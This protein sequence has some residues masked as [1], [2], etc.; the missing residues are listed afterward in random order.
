[1][2]VRFV[3]FLIL[4]MGLIPALSGQSYDKMWKKVQAMQK[5]DRPR[6][7]LDLTA[8]IYR[9]ANR[10]RNVP[11]ML[12]AYVSGMEFREKITPDS[13]SRDI[14]G[15][16][17]W[18]AATKEPLDAAVLHS[19][20]AEMY[21]DYF[22][23]RPLPSYRAAELSENNTELSEW[24]GT[25]FV[26]KIFGH[27]RASLHDQELL[28]K[29]SVDA[30]RPVVEKGATSAYFGH[31][32][33][34]LLGQRAVA[35]LEPLKWRVSDFYP[36]TQS[37][38]EDAFPATPEFLNRTILQ[39]SDYDCLGE[40]LRIDQSM[41]RHYTATGDLRAAVLV[42]LNRVNLS[43][44]NTGRDVARPAGNFETFS[45]SPY[46]QALTR[47]SERY[48]P[49]DVCA[50]VYKKMADVALAN[51]FPSQAMRIV[52]D[53]LQ[54]YPDYDRINLFRQLESDILEPRLSGRSVETVYP[55]Q[56]FGID[57][58]YRN[59]AGFTLKLYRVNVPVTSELLD[60]PNEKSFRSRSVKLEKSFRY[61]LAP[62]PDYLEKDTSV[63]VAAP[64]EGVWLMEIVPDAKVNGTTSWLLY[65]TRL[66]AINRALPGGL[67]EFV[68]VDARSGYPVA[69]A[70]V[71]LYRQDENRM[72]LSGQ[73]KTGPDGTAGAKE[74]RYD[75]YRALKGNDQAMP[76]NRTG[77]IRYGRSYNS[78]SSKE[79]SLFTDRGIYRP[80]QTVYV[81]GIAYRTDGDSVRVLA[82]SEYTLSLYDVNQ[83][84]LAQKKVKTNEF[85][86]FAG[87]FQLPA[88]CLPGSFNIRAGGI[89]AWFR[90]EE[91]KR[92]TFDVTFNTIRTAY[93]IG[94]SVWVSGSAR[95]YSGVPVQNAEV[96]YTFKISYPYWL[97]AGS[98]VNLASGTVRTDENGVFRV[99]VCL[100]SR[101]DNLRFGGFSYNYVLNADVT[102]GAGE[103]QNGIFRIPSGKN[104]LVVR[105]E[106]PQNLQKE[107][108]DSL[109][110]QVRN[111][112]GVPQSVG[113]VLE[114]FKLSPGVNSLPPVQGERVLREAFV[115]NKAFRPASILSLSPGMYRLTF[116]VTGADGKAVSD[117]SDFVLYSLDDPRPP[118]RTDCW[119]QV[120]EPEFGPDQPATVLFGTSQKDVYLLYDVFAGEKHLES[121]RIMLTDSVLKLVYPY[122]SE[123]ADGL[124]VQFAFVKNEKF[125]QESTALTK[126]LPDKKLTMQW[127]T[128]RDKLRPGEQEEWKLRIVTPGGKAADAELLAAMYDA[129]LDKLAKSNWF[130][131]LYFQRRIPRIQWNT[132]YPQTAYFNLTFSEKQWKYKALAYDRFVFGPLS[133][134]FVEEEALLAESVVTGTGN[135]YSPGPVMAKMRVAGMDVTAGN[136]AVSYES[137]QIKDDELQPAEEGEVRD[138]FAET[139]F[140]YPQLRTDR[141]GV[142]KISFLLPQS[143]TQWRFRGLAHTRTMDWGQID[144]LATA[145]K[146][147]MIAPN[148]P[149]FVR[150]GDQVS[151]AANVINLTGKEIAGTAVMELFDP[152]NEKVYVSQKQKFA[153]GAGETSTVGFSFAVAGNYP[154]LLACRMTAKGNGF[155]DGE[156]RYLP[157]LSNKQQITESIPVVVE[158]PGSETFRL[159]SLFNND[160]KSATDRR[161]TVEFTGNPAWYAVQALPSLSNPAN[162][163]AIAWASAYYA[164]S[165]A[166][167]IAIAN[168]RIKAVFDSWM[169]QG[170]TKETLLSNLEKNQELKNILL[171]ETP[172]AVEATNETEQK[173]RIATL[174]DLNTIRYTNS[175]VIDK[176]KSLQQNGAWS[177]FKGMEASPYVTLFVAEALGRVPVLTGEPLSPDAGQLLTATWS[178]LNRQAK[179]TYA[180]MVKAESSGGGPATISD[181]ILR[182]LYLGA[183]TGENIHQADPKAYDYFLNRIARTITGQNL[184]QKALSAVILQQAGRKAEAANFIQS[185]K[186]YAVRSPGMGTYYDSRSAPYSAGS[187]RIPVQVDVLEA[188]QR[189]A[190]D[191]EIV[192]QMKIWLLRQKQ[193]Q[194][195][196][197]PVATVN[198]VYALFGRGSDL[199]AGDGGVKITLGKQ[200]IETDP[201]NSVAAGLGYVKQTF[202]GKQIEP[203]MNT[204]TVTKSGEGI[205]WGAVY[206]QYLENI[207]NVTRQGGP[208]SV[209]KKLFVERM[210]NNRPVLIPLSRAGELSTGEKVV[211]RL[212]VKTDRDMDFIQLKD[213]RA[214]CLEPVSSLSGYQVI[215]NQGCY[216][217][218]KDASAEFFFD[219]LRK[220]TY[221]IEY[222]CF[223][224][225]KGDYSGG[226]ATLQSA[227]APEFTA[228][229]ASEQVK[230][231]K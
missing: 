69:D 49:V 222:A 53:A 107:G 43:Y 153:V 114:V 94:D 99:K 17:Q 40:M 70:D 191:P 183:I 54:K 41:L 163:N 172:W 108:N 16:E 118:Y 136:G 37:N 187:Y 144:A 178:Y 85:G 203:G 225:R 230:V 71:I 81:A 207:S 221:L 181:F 91:Y 3:S 127:E 219:G 56:P 160:S 174:F 47:L 189:V 167:Y 77:M 147:F 67:T 212:T 55:D 117:E 142:A 162:D 214:A 28:E 32:L 50:E 226:I 115:P 165:V 66:K 177:W 176:L 87:E 155:S 90:V 84:M 38:L 21:A 173:Q 34:H 105:C 27:L 179:E 145:S 132:A 122:R 223:I 151:I 76:F 6:S 7:A 15:L 51:G 65:V 30:F 97:R 208:L 210:E 166:S 60:D 135:L 22:T 171:D 74:L 124:Y 52:R 169:Q 20:L 224:T 75:A 220:G 194:A 18:L 73:L 19:V 188:I 140:F 138:N 29:T 92:P 120:V 215:N 9:K 217:A 42:D 182:Y 110:V 158:G 134:V 113:G 141:D 82:N 193:T 95:T 39:A 25:Q 129:S 190:N 202:A 79:L 1:M 62:T 116:S 186:E 12:K 63:Q 209:D 104:A 93:Q 14:L 103:T 64:S 88:P 10:E 121:K 180:S 44:E 213:S 137:S 61:S 4:F 159:S 26:R 35:V 72:S 170:G 168:P 229:S 200:T 184:D 111:L 125:Y 106:V 197:S 199:L 58:N 5:L 59:L 211:A 175:I 46:Y 45:T 131:N 198:A 36:Q 192:E 89:R 228:H 154:A 98:D 133:S 146:E 156:Q 205:G 161:L 216:V 130:F 2:R 185:L 149:R 109:T 31:D 102:D 8:E 123:Y 139:A 218:V 112:D 196:D 83:K 23:S 100:Q 231:T 119:F 86:S 143:L 157:V 164:N 150:T 48:A 152:E 24:S 96:K 201:G 227:Y 204:L 11:E 206:A 101:P 68:V 33:F 126:I 57:I 128:F 78:G 13:L 80:G 148:L 195:W